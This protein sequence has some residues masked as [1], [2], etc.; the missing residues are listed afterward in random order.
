MELLQPYKYKLEAVLE[1]LRLANKPNTEAQLRAILDKTIALLGADRGTLYAV[2]GERGELHS[3]ILL[4]GGKT[5]EIRLKIGKGL[6]GW[7]A[8]AGV[9][10]VIN[11]VLQDDRFDARWDRRSGYRTHTMLAV[12]L[13]NPRN[14][15][16]GVIQLLNKPKGFDDLDQ[17]I[18]ESIAAV[19]AIAQDNL[20]L[21]E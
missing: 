17:R 8:M 6:A 4:D 20:R 18:L 9:P 13:R 16:T 15:I 21:Q 11:D 2:D 1:I 12:P 5:L 19:C 10:L 14:K 7:V 3:T